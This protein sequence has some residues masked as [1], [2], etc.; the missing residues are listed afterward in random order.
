MQ[1]PTDRVLV[2][3]GATVTNFKTPLLDKCLAYSA[4]QDQYVV[5]E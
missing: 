3:W 5:Q 1:S 4:Y 2:F